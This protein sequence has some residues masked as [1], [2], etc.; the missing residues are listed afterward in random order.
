MLLVEDLTLDIP[1]ADAW[2]SHRLQLKCGSVLHLCGDNG[3]G[4]STFLRCL[5]G[6]Y[7]AK[8]KLSFDGGAHNY[9]SLDWPSLFTVIQN[10]YNGL[11]H[12]VGDCLRMLYAI[13][14]SK[15]ITPIDMQNVAVKLQLPTDAVCTKLSMGQKK[16]LM[17]APFLFVKRRIWLLDEPFVYLDDLW[18]EQ[19]LEWIS[20]CKQADAVIVLSMHNAGSKVKHVIDDVFRLERVN[21]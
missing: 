6:L 10:D 17:L 2:C 11:V 4:K 15:P 12:T 20:L 3:V 19:L 18:C 21:V 5:A 9:S 7:P 13:Y 14:M 16:R 1:H 8:G